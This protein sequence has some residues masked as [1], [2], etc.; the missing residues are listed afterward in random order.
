MNLGFDLN[1]W[2][3]I[4]AIESGEFESL[5]LGGH[6]VEI[7]DARVYKNENNGNVSL[8]VCVDIAKDDKQA[9]YFKKQYE[10]NSNANKKWS[11][12]ATRYLS[13]KKENLKYLKGFV[14]TTLPN[15]NPNFKFDKTK[16]WE[17][18]NN[19]K[20]VGVFGLEEYEKQDGTIGTATKLVQFRS[21]DK[22]NQVKIPKVKLIDGSSMD[23][24]EYRNRKNDNANLSQLDTDDA[25]TINPED[26][27]F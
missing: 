18:I 11:N 4:E 6:V 20:C 5:S 26:L 16:G 9:G 21:L 19:L 7:V 22:L 12:G 15:S 8:K 23:Y 2:D 10:E 25:V 17:Q 3:S 14:E 13:L 24:E 27:P 1:E